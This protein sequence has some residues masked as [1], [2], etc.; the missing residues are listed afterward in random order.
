MKNIDRL[1]ED[2]LAIRKEYREY[3]A[4]LQQGAPGFSPE[5]Q[6]GLEK[7]FLN[8]KAFLIQALRK[9]GRQVQAAEV[10]ATLNLTD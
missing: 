4:N 2:T 1:L 6:R 7:K 3:A 10:A 5:G 9:N 8:T